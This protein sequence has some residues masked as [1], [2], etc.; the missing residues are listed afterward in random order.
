MKKRTNPVA[1]LL[2]FVLSMMV[3]LLL[4]PLFLGSCGIPTDLDDAEGKL[5]VVASI[6]PLYEFSREVGGDAADVTLLLPPGLSPHSFEPTPRDIK[7]IRDADIFIFN[8]AKMEPWLDDVISGKDN[9]DLIVVDAGDGVKSLMVSDGHDDHDGRDNGDSLRGVD[10]H[11]WLDFDNAQM[12]VNNILKAYIE[13]DQ[14]NSALYEER[15]RA[16]NERLTELDLLYKDA[17]KNCSVND[18]ISSGHFAFGYMARRYGFDHHSVFDISHGTEPTPK[19]L[20]EIIETIK[21]EKI[22]Y[23]FAEELVDSRLARTLRE[24]TGAEILLV[25]PAGNISKKMFDSGTTFI[26][27]MED[28]LKKFRLGLNCK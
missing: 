13:V 16:Y 27:I 2:Q 1:F 11:F 15:A 26:E 4:S 24:E 6:F 23:V 10:P 22:K 20:I 12:Q 28:N 8:G 25:S 3:L 19:K 21:G 7:L 17:L 14:D 5:K 18:I 9:R